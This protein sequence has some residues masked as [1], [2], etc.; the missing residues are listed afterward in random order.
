MKLREPKGQRRLKAREVLGSVEAGDQGFDIVQHVP[1]EF[2]DETS[3]IEHVLAVDLNSFSNLQNLSRMAQLNP[4]LARRLYSHRELYASIEEQVKEGWHTVLGSTVNPPNAYALN[5]V[6]V[7]LEVFP[8]LRSVL[9]KPTDTQF[10]KLLSGA[11]VVMQNSMGDDLKV[12]ID[13]LQAFPERSVQIREALDQSEVKTKF[14]EK[15]DQVI[16]AVFTSP[17]TRYELLGLAAVL[18]PQ[19]ASIYKARAKSDWT[20]VAKTLANLKDGSNSWAGKIV[21][22]AAVL[23]AP[24]PHI[25]DKGKLVLREESPIEKRRPLPER[26]VA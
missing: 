26:A 8:E 9:R 19:D 24:S 2:W 7:F 12:P 16:T 1:P 22:A 11:L 20:A 13:L 14:V 25:D 23:N 17:Q 10:N 4:D 5:H 3:I 15:L 21:W 18:Y 6:V